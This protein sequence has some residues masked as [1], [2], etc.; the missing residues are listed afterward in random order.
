VVRVSVEA[1][2]RERVNALFTSRTDLSQK[3]LA[4]ALKVSPSW[5]SAFLAGRRNANDLPLLTKIARF[6]G[7]SVGYLLGETERGLRADAM[8]LLAKYEELEPPDRD[9]V[10]QLALTLWRRGGSGGGEGQEGPPSGSAPA[11]RGNK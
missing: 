1:I 10:L 11:K 7:V 9:A 2:V 5:V 4:A 8:I 3:E 6:F